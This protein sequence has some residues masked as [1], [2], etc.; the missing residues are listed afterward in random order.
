MK[1]KIKDILEKHYYG[2]NF[3]EAK[4]ADELFELFVKS[5]PNADWE[6]TL[7]AENDP[8]KFCKCTCSNSLQYSNCDK[9]CEII[10]DDQ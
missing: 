2:R 8:P 7:K 6:A 10:L 4:C 5:N 9:M 1:E 3:I